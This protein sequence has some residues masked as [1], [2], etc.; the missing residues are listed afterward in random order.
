MLLTISIK[1]C[2]YLLIWPAEKGK[3]FNFQWN[4]LKRGFFFKPFFPSFDVLHSSPIGY[5]NHTELIFQE[6]LLYCTKMVAENHNHFFHFR[7]GGETHFL[8]LTQ[9]LIYGSGCLI[10]VYQR[11]TYQ[12]KTDKQ[13]GIFEHLW[14]F[15]RTNSWLSHDFLM[16][17]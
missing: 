15:L 10:H 16:T 3:H 6:L 17:F 2:F 11:L 5:K 7:H 4:H 1:T 14:D 8:V 12:H 13:F 9:T